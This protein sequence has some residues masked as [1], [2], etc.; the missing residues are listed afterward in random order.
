MGYLKKLGTKGGKNGDGQKINFYFMK[1][2][3]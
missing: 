1:L 3:D 2:Q